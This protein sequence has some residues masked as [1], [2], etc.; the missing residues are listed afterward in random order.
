MKIKRFTEDVGFD[1]DELK[2]RYEIPNLMGEFEPGSSSLRPLFLH[3]NKIN[4]E[5]E[6]KKLLFKFPILERLRKNTKRL[7]GSILVSF[8]AT[9]KIPLEDDSEF[10]AQISFAY[11]D[12]QYYI[13]TVLRDIEDHE[14][15]SKWIRHT[16]NF[17]NLEGVYPIA[18]AFVQISKR[19][20][21]IDDSDL[22]P[23][24]LKLN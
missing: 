1:D 21:I 3:S 18:E 4:T 9:S 22:L 6:L 11:H 24:N 20:N 17:D 23:Y 2:Y 12:G 14:D 5:N 16:F 7:E 15:E 19:L 13:G 10:Y 8:Y